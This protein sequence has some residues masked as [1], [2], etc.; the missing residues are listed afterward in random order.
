MDFS[1]AIINYFNR[2]LEVENDSITQMLDGEVNCDEVL[3][4][5]GHSGSHWTYHAHPSTKPRH[6]QKK[7]LNRDAWI[8][9]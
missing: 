2:T 3:D 7:F 9:F 4:T 6:L 8:W 1:P 5:I